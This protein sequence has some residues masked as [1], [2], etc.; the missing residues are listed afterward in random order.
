MERAVVEG[1]GKI[2]GGL[3][4]DGD[5]TPLDR[6][7]TEHRPPEWDV[8]VRP[9]EEGMRVSLDVR[10]D[11]RPLHSIQ[12]LGKTYLA[13]PRWGTE[14]DIQVWNHGP[15]R[16]TALVAVD[17]LSVING[18]PASENQPGYIVAPYSSM[19]IKGWRRNLEKVAAFTFEER[20]KSYAY[21]MGWQENIGVIGLVAIEERVWHPRPLLD[22]EEARSTLAKQ[23]R[24]EVGHTGTG[25]GRDVDS[26]VQ[27]VPFVRSTNKRTITLYYDTV[28]ALAKAGVPVDR[29]FPVPF[30]ADR[31]FASPPVGDPR[32]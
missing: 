27:Y 4:G 17:G 14:Y 18:R 9:R 12:H 2:R 15:R 28:D 16:I 6:F 13:V 3:S 23:A 30:P 26:P 11:G 5:Q 21:L 1:T 32:K 25:Y 10:I 29:P 19:V 20:E 22:K 31:E 24:A 7:L 8:T